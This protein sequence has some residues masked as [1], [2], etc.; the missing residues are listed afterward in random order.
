MGFCAPLFTFTM[1]HALSP[2][3]FVRSAV[4]ALVLSGQRYHIPEQEGGSQLRW[5]DE[6]LCKDLNR[7]RRPRCYLERSATVWNGL[8]S[9]GS[10]V[11]E[12]VPSLRFQSS[13]TAGFTVRNLELSPQGTYSHHSRQMVGYARLIQ[14]RRSALRPR[15]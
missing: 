8:S 14:V 9:P 3:G 7:A 6:A 4:S 11:M 12:T 13:G 2:F 5:F 15:G 1:G 10:F